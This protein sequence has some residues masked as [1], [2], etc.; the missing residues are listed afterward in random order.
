MQNQIPLNSTYQRSLL[1][2]HVIV[3]IKDMIKGYLTTKQASLIYGLSDAHI[4]RLLEHKKIKGEKFGRDW[5][6]RPRAME[7][8]MENRPKPGP[9]KGARNGRNHKD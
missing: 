2:A 4:R 7:R 6:I 5:L 8:Y 9:R 1:I 3:Y